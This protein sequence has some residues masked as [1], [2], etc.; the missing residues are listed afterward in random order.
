MT[1]SRSKDDEWNLG[2]LQ[3]THREDS[4]VDVDA[5]HGVPV[6]VA[7]KPENAP[8]ECRDV[9]ETN[10]DRARDDYRAR[11]SWR[12]DRERSVITPFVA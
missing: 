2:G 3:T 8:R 12:R 10:H 11:V 1:G 6:V 4:G 9:R 5:P 7:A